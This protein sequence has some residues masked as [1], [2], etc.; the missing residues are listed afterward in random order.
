MTD[1]FEQF[2]DWLEYNFP[3]TQWTPFQEEVLRTVMKDK[4]PRTSKE[5]AQRFK[6]LLPKPRK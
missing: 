2:E 6:D 4:V 5:L 3:G 1:L